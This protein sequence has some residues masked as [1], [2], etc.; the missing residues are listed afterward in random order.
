MSILMVSKCLIPGKVPKRGKA[1]I[2]RFTY[3]NERGGFHV[4]VQ[5]LD[6]QHP[7]KDSVVHFFSLFPGDISF[8]GRGRLDLRWAW[9]RGIPFLSGHGTACVDVPYHFKSFQR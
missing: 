6:V 2:C 7:E 5:R 9:L 3:L 8:R 4:L 1:H